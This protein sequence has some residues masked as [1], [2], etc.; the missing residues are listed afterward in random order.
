M[1]FPVAAGSRCRDAQD[2]SGIV[3]FTPSFRIAEDFS[4]LLV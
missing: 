3:S 4:I 2:A 1:N